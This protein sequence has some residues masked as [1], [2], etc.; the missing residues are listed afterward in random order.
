MRGRFAAVVVSTVPLKSL[1]VTPPSPVLMEPEYVTVTSMLAL[2]QPS[3]AVT[4]TTPPR[5]E[6]VV[7]TLPFT[8]PAGESSLRVTVKV[9]L[10]V[11]SVLWPFTVALALNVTGV[12]AATVVLEADTISALAPG[13]QAPP[14]PVEPPPVAPPP[15]APPPVVP[16]PVAPPPAPPP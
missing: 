12:P 7:H 8:V 13:M 9:T 6:A 4:C 2:E 5:P 11:T 3:L 15:V 1:A 14:P 16:P 10:E